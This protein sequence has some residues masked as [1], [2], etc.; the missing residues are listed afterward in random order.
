[1]ECYRIGDI[2]WIRTCISSYLHPFVVEDDTT[3][4]FLLSDRKIDY[5]YYKAPGSGEGSWSFV[6]WREFQE[7]NSA[8]LFDS[9]GSLIFHLDCYD[10]NSSNPLIQNATLMIEK[11]LSEGYEGFDLMEKFV[12]QFY[13]STTDVKLSRDELADLTVELGVLLAKKSDWNSETYHGISFDTP[14]EKTKK[15]LI[16]I[17]SG[18]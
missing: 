6:A 14:T 4:Q 1:M 8:Y 17:K 11:L 2:H 5:N 10:F 18:D 12:L 15:Y 16:H 9:T 13:D 3:L 7:E